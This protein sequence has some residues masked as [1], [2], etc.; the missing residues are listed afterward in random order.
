MSDLKEWLIEK[1]CYDCYKILRDNNVT[2]A[3]LGYVSTKQLTNVGLTVDQQ[4][5]LFNAAHGN[6]QKKVHPEKVPLPGL[7]VSVLNNDSKGNVTISDMVVEK[8]EPK[9]KFS[10]FAKCPR[11]GGLG[12][13]SAWKNLVRTYNVRS[14]ADEI[15]AC[16]VIFG[17]AILISSICCC[18]TCFISEKCGA[19][20]LS[21]KRQEQKKIDRK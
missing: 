15:G 8:L 13:V 21:R 5:R 2:V 6:N 17:G 3:M 4:R 1:N 16:S 7:S 20:E 19:C 18:G 9:A 12:K 10:G 14:G 11:C